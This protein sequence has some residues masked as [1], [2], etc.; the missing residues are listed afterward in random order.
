[1]LSS[2]N[3]TRNNKLFSLAVISGNKHAVNYF[4]E[5]G[6][7]VNSIGSHTRTLLMDAVVAGHIDICKS[8]LKA[9][10]DPLYE[11]KNGHTA[12]SL[13]KNSED[14]HLIYLLDNFIDNKEKSLKE[15]DALIFDFGDES[16]VS[17]EADNESTI[18]KSDMD[19][20]EKLRSDHH[21]ISAY[22]TIDSDENFDDIDIDFPDIFIKKH[23]KKTRIK[24]PLNKYL[25]DILSFGYANGVFHKKDYE[26]EI[27]EQ[28]MFKYSDLQGS[29]EAAFSASGIDILD[30][31]ILIPF[32]SKDSVSDFFSDFQV[33][34]MFDYM[35]LELDG[36]RNPLAMFLNE[37]ARYPLL[38]DDQV[39][40]CCKDIKNSYFKLITIIS[41]EFNIFEQLLNEVDR[42]LQH[43]NP[44]EDFI[45]SETSTGQFDDTSID[46]VLHSISRLSKNDLKERVHLI[47]ERNPNKTDKIFT[48]LVDLVLDW[49]FLIHTYKHISLKN[50][51][52]ILVMNNAINNYRNAKDLM[53]NSNLRLVYSIARKYSRFGIP[54]LDLIQEGTIGLMKAID[55]FDF[56][57]GNK[58]S[59]YATWWIRQAITRSIS[60]DKEIIRIP[61]HMYESIK[62]LKQAEIYLSQYPAIL[63]PDLEIARFLQWTLNRV[64]T[65]KNA[66][67]KIIALDELIDSELVENW[68]SCLVD[69]IEEHD[70]EYLCKLKDLRNHEF[71]SLKILTERE[72][73]ILLY[74]FGF[75]DGEIFTLNTLGEMYDVTRERIRQIESKGLKK[76]RSNK[77]LRRFREYIFE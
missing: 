33:D 34:E 67:K 46:Y 13:A 19:L 20:V 72:K 71:Q 40:T 4:I 15:S 48:S 60:N 73:D 57:M 69:D 35:E 77:Y 55:R 12:I 10:A 49:E 61:V 21:E 64:I 28:K 59:T 5:S 52:I 14:N 38:A 58:F 22:I 23:P 3:N 36:N 18:P 39:E 68:E 54:V 70:P 24:E 9:G 1:L 76:L 11:D 16:E 2:S 29:L 6:E 8:L 26:V 75:H 44:E 53:V 43:D 51:D 30:S 74:R 42:Y 62:K 37:A 7:N 31:D 25:R 65:V 27:T 32:Y 50:E 41:S 45:A 47:K 66:Q 56:E 17:W 63:V